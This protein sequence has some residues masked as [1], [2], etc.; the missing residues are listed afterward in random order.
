ERPHL[1]DAGSLP[2]TSVTARRGALRVEALAESPGSHTLTGT[3]G[4]RTYR[5]TV[6]VTDP[7]EPI[8][9]DGDWTLTLHQDG[10]Q[11][12]VRPLGSWSDIARLFSGSATY[13]KEITLD[14]AAL[15]GRRLHL[16]LGTVR[17][18]AQVTVNGTA[19]PPALWIPYVVDVTDAL[20]PGTNHI[21]VRVSNTLSN[22][23]NKPLPSGL[24]GPVFLRPRRPVTADLH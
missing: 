22:E 4:R 10:A 15:E 16:D 20:R 5:G 7:L 2:V 9:L 1:S 6:R 21:A 8:P 11:P 24:L 13:T 23:R 14:T 12:V 19:L 17:E 18:V 3:D